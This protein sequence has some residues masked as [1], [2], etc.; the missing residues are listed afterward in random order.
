MTSMTIIR[1]PQHGQ[2]GR[3]SASSARSVASAAG[4]GTWP[5][6]SRNRLILA[7]RPVL[8]PRSDRAELRD[9]SPVQAFD[10]SLKS[11]LRHVAEGACLVPIDRERLVVKQDFRARRPVQ[12]CRAAGTGL[13]QVRR[14]RSCPPPARLGRFPVA[15]SLAGPGLQLHRWAGVSP[16]LPLRAPAAPPS[17]AETRCPHFSSISYLH[18]LPGQ[19]SRPLILPKRVWRFKPAASRMV[20]DPERGSASPDTETLFDHRIYPKALRPVLVAKDVITG[21]RHSSAAKF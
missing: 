6:S 15:V 18:R 7:A 19:S 13:R 20:R 1:L 21:L 16:R 17:S 8:A 11:S 10:R 2:G 9:L 12:G 4:A 14:P 3:T 5:S